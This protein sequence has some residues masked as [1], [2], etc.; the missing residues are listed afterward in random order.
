[1]EE[2]AKDSNPQL[3][4]KKTKQMLIT[5]NV[6]PSL[7]VKGQTLERVRTFKLLGTRLNENLKCTDHVKKLVSSC[8]KV[9]SILRKI[10][11]MHG[12]TASKKAVKGQTLE[13]VRTFKL[14]GTRLNEN[15]KCT[16]HVKKLVSSCHKVLSILRKIRN[17]HGSTASK[18]AISG[19]SHHFNFKVDYNRI[20]CY[21]LP[22]YLQEKVQRVRN[23]DASFVRNRYSTKQDFRNLGWLPPL[24]RRNC[25]S[26]NLLTVR[27]IRIPGSN[28]CL[29]HY[30]TLKRTYDQVIHYSSYPYGETYLSGLSS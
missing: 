1:M 11:N 23:V 24:K 14:L 22:A 5:C 2:W 3:N 20:V 7:T 30:M 25:T 8:H 6:I 15:L 18:K 28:I 19:K 26:S 10:R 4:E 13:R 29:C 27:Y 12:S 16:D 9:L 17:M 21:P